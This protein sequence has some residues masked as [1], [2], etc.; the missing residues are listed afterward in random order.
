MIKCRATS[1]PVDQIET[2]CAVL[3]FFNDERPL[4]GMVGL[5][6]WR[7]CGSLSRLIMENSIDGH[8][9]EVVMFPVRNKKLKTE[10]V[11]ILGL[12][13]KA[14]YNFE[15]FSVSI[16]KILDT[17]FKLQINDFTLELPGLCGTD[18]DIAMAAHRFCEALA[19]RYRDDRDLFSKMQITVISK[20]EYIKKLN[21]VFTAFEKKTRDELGLV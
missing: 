19:I 15:T 12:G 5:A 2:R 9:G 14:Q 3:T 17:L 20:P 1:A 7:L 13:P 4:K 6:D 16:R 8:F 21:P 11:V 18:L 10:R